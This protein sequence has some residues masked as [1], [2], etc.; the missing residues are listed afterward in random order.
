MLEFESLFSAKITLAPA[1]EL[2][3]GPQGR[4][5]I[6][7]ITGGAVSGPRLSGRVLPGGAD[8]Q[9]VRPD[10]V[11]YL[12]ARYTIET[13]DSALVYV[14]NRGYRHGPPEVVARLAAGE[15]VD[16][17]LYYMRTTPWFETG[18]VRYAWLNRTVCVGSGERLANAVWIDFYAVK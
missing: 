15:A 9:I 8:W 3:D 6:I 17:G 1:Q 11:A 2:G 13:D 10:G 14:R 7:P 12:D 16:P 18:D 5:R 4:R